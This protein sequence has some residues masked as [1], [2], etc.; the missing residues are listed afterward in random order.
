VTRAR[1]NL[2]TDPV[3]VEIPTNKIS[4]TRARKSLRTGHVMTEIPTM[5]LKIIIPD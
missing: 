3:R 5:Y 1:R 2:N 4:V